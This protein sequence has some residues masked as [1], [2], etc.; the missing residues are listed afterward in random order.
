MGGD[1]F[2]IFIV[3]NSSLN[4]ELKMQYLKLLFEEYNNSNKHKLEISYGYA[5]RKAGEDIS[6]EDLYKEADKNMYKDK[7][8][9]KG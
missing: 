2:C 7:I 3:N 6:V 8:K 5:T 9:N 1:E 4:I